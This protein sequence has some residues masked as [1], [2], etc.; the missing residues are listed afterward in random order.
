MKKDR[1]LGLKNLDMINVPLMPRFR[2]C[3]CR[4]LCPVLRFGWRK[5]DYLS[6]AVTCFLLFIRYF[7]YVYGDRKQ[8]LQ[9]LVNISTSREKKV[10]C[11]RYG[12]VGAIRLRLL[13]ILLT[14]VR[15]PN[16]SQRAVCAVDTCFR[17]KL[18]LIGASLRVSWHCFSFV[19]FVDQE[20]KKR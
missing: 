7:R 1:H 9:E 17:F 14:F 3:F 19:R 8:E 20:F 13:Q 6:Q 11:C 2:T 16:N 18:V 12:C 10:W 5:R 4:D 15:D